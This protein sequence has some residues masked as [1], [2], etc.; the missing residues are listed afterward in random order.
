[1]PSHD[2]SLGKMHPCPLCT[3]SAG[4][5]RVC[6]VLLEVFCP[7]GALGSLF[8]FSA[9]YIFVFWSFFFNL[10]STV[11]ISFSP[12]VISPLLFLLFWFLKFS[13]D[14]LVSMW[15]WKSIKTV[16]MKRRSALPAHLSVAV[17]EY[18]WT[19]HSASASILHQRWASSPAREGNHAHFWCQR[20]ALIVPPLWSVK[21]E[22]AEGHHCPFQQPDP[23]PTW[24][25]GWDGTRS[26]SW[27]GDR[28]IWADLLCTDKCNL[29]T[30]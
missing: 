17:R 13:R 7:H 24:S 14:G 22:A 16:V 5:F 18:S 23:K 10:S 30:L 20:T 27:D 1:M 8:Y 11:I 21:C 3:G 28:Q 6:W 15:L 4:F 26:W 19:G 29:L 12:S 25:Q 9:F 2:T